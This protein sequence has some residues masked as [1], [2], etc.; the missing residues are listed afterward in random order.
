VNDRHD[1][2]AWEYVLHE[3]AS[4]CGIRV[5]V[6]EARRFG[7][8]AHTF[9]VRRF[10]RRETGARIHFA[11]AM[12]LTGHVDGESASYLEIADVLASQ[13]AEAGDDLLELWTRIVFNIMASNTDDHL[14]NHGFLL[15]PNGWRL[16][17]AYDMNPNPDSLGLA[18]DIDDSDNALDLDLVRSV[19][20]YFRVQDVEATIGRVRETM[21]GWREV[22]AQLGIKGGEQ[23]M[24]A[25]AF[26][27][28]Q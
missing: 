2:G 7:G 28:V 25:P 14:R 8:V 1:A 6:A 21:A 5:P 23:D 17:P 4:R 11:S 3:L 27:A 19:A 9:L 18:L 16:S 10:D 20:R 22:A 26:R 13:G 15:T 12:T 24:M